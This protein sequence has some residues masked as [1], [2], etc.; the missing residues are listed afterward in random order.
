MLSRLTIHG[1][2]V[3][4]AGLTALLVGCAS[5]PSRVVEPSARVLALAPEVEN[6]EA[7]WRA[8]L[9]VD[10]DHWAYGRNDDRL[11]SEPA[12][13]PLEE[14]SIIER[15]RSRTVGGRPFDQYTRWVTIWHR[16]VR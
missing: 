14:V 8:S 7:A 5:A 4:V 15:D 13:R 2:R 3:A 6:T 9:L 16:T 11:G 12:V 1:E 10:P